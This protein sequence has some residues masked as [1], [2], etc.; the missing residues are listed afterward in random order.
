MTR[1]SELQFFGMHH[2]YKLFVRM[3]RFTKWG[4]CVVGLSIIPFMPLIDEP[5]EE[6]IDGA[7]LKFW[8]PPTQSAEPPA[9]TTAA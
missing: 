1:R 3:S 9:P 7:F 6:L 8:P 4:P 2:R 5:V